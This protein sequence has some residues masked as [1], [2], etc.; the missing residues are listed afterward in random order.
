MSKQL[1][2]NDYRT[3]HA[4]VV[5]ACVKLMSRHCLNDDGSQM[6]EKDLREFF[7]KQCTYHDEFAGK[8]SPEEVAEAQWEAIT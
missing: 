4:M 5:D 1:M 6:S 3:Y 8:Q 7:D 2:P